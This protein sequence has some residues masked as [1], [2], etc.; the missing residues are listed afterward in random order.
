MKFRVTDECKWVHEFSAAQAQ[1]LQAGI[2]RA[3]EHYAEDL[4]REAIATRRRLY[5]LKLHL[6]VWTPVPGPKVFGM[7]T[8]PNWKSANSP[9]VHQLVTGAE[10]RDLLAA[11]ARMVEHVAALGGLADHVDDVVRRGM[12]GGP[13]RDDDDDDDD[14][15][16]T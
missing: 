4:E 2:R 11:C 5:P 8:N 7:W 3:C 15:G 12:Y 6:H 14:A 13:R 9:I 1:T 16:K 10:A